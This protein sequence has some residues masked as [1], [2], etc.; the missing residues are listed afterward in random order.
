MKHKQKLLSLCATFIFGS[1]LLHSQCSEL[2]FSEYV[3]GYYNNKALEIYNPGTKS[4]YLGN[5]RITTWHNGNSNFV[6]WY[7]DTL[8]DSIGP[9]QVR[10]VVINKR[11]TAAKGL[12]TMVNK[13]LADR[14]DIWLS[15]N[16]P[17]SMSLNFNGDDPV[18][19]DKKTSSWWQ[20]VD[21]IGKVGEQPQDPGNPSAT[22]GWSDSFPFRT[23]K[24]VLYTKDHTLIRKRSV[25]FGVNVNPSYFNPKTEWTAYKVNLFD[26]L[27]THQC[28][29]NKFSAP[30]TVP[31]R[32]SLFVFP[33]PAKDKLCVS[34]LAAGR[35]LQCADVSGR[36]VTLQWESS[37]AGGFAMLVA[38]ISA[39]RPGVYWLLSE[40]GAAASWVKLP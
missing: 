7:S 17:A 3:E 30:V 38:D 39:L 29:C 27:G 13:A 16:K 18:T 26:S 25:R 12:D 10:V 33:V 15:Q 28:D 37:V 8:T 31:V 20:P 14:A 32:E 11:D 35:Q 36:L 40:S 21:I 22:I 9:N 6:D 19:L 2:F 34:G 23:G 4:V 5:Y 1:G 24:G